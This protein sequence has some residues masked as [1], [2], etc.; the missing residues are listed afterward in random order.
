LN[1]KIYDKIQDRLKEFLEVET[2]EFIKESEESLGDIIPKVNIHI[3]ESL[4]AAVT[5]LVAASFLGAGALTLAEFGLLAVLGV[6]GMAA[7]VALGI[8]GIIY[9]ASWSKESVA[10]ESTLK[11]VDTLATDKF[12]QTLLAISMSALDKIILKIIE[13]KQDNILEEFCKKPTAQ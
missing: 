13:K 8:V 5:G 9:S 3:E 10:K 11:S 4:G 12:R 6:A 7:T 1:K 2:A